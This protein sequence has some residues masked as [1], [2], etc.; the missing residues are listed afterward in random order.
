VVA[1]IPVGTV[2]GLSN[3]LGVATNPETN[4]AYI[5]NNGDN[6][7]SVLVSFDPDEQQA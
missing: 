4:T 5:A 2:P 7:V 6:T 3:P 1:T